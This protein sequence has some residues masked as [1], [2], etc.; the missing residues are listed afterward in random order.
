MTHPITQLLPTPFAWVEIPGGS[1]TLSE[2]GGYLDQPRTVAV[3]P[4]R[5]AQYPITNAQ[6]QVFVDASDGFGDAEWWDFSDDARAWRYDYGRPKLPEFGGDHP[7]TH[8]NWY[9]AVA[10]CRWLSAHSGES[11][12]LPVEAEWQ[13]AAQGDDGRAY[14]WGDEWD[15]DRCTH[16]LRHANIGTASVHEHVGAGDSPFG[17]SDLC[18]NVWEWT[19]TGWDRGA[20]VLPAD[21]PRVLRGGSWFDD[22]MSVFRTA[23]R[24]SWTPDLESDLRGFRIVSG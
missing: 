7:R 9:A 19:A 5:I 12:R 2:R 11:I 4:F 8:V 15:S 20:P 10:F 23:K 3:A 14:P 6:F 18:G 17:V 16:N 21:E 13:R 24:S 1:V 22:V